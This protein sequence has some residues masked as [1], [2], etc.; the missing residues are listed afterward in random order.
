MNP[1]IIKKIK[2]IIDSPLA[3]E[4]VYSALTFAVELQSD[5]TLENIDDK[6]IHHLNQGLQDWDAQ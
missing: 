5:T 3:I 2:E 1:E 6:I 4:V